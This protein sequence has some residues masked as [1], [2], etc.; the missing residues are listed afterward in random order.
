MDTLLQDI[1]YSARKLLRTPGFT[2]VAVATLALAIGATTAVFSLVNGILLQPLPYAAPHELVRVGSTRTGP[3]GGEQPVSMSRMDFLDYEA[4]STSF[5]GMAAINTTTLNL[6]G[7]GADPLRLD[8]A[9]VTVNFFDVLGVPLQ[10]GRGFAKGE[11]APGTGRVVVLSDAIWRS[12]FGADPG[13]VGREITLNGARH[14][15]VGIAPP[16]LTYPGR[17]EAWVPLAP[18][19][20]ELDPEN[21]GAHYLSG[22]GRLKPGVAPE[23]ARRELAT[24]AER[25]EAQ[26]PESNTNFG[27]TA[28]PLQEWIVGDVRPALYAMLGAVGFVL[29]I[30]CSNVANLL[31]VRASSRE[32][33]LAVRTALGAKRGRLVRQLVTESVMLSVAGA[34]LG[35]AIALWVVDAVVAL[36]PEGLPRLAEVRVDAR[37]LGATALLALL[38][39]VG[40]GLIPA[41]HAARS[42][43]GQ[44]LRESGRGTSHRK[45]TNR[46]RSL[47]VVTEFALAVVLLVGAGL[48]IRSFAALVRVD[49]GFRAENV[50]TATVSLPGGKYTY[51]R[52]QRAFADAVLERME[53]LPGAQS[54]ALGFGRPLQQNN[55]RTTFDVEGRPPNPPERRTPVEV[56]PTT[57]DFFRTLGIPLV[58]GRLYTRD[59]RNGAPPV[60][61]VNEEFVRR[62]FAGED[63]I[64]KRIVL[65]WGRDTAEVGES[66][67]VGGEI[68]GIVGDVKQFGL[69]E[70]TFPTAFL[71]FHQTPLSDVSIMVRSTAAPAAVQR[72]MRGQIKEIDPDLPVFDVMTM[73][74]ALAESVAQPRFYMMLL[75]GFAG[76]ALLLAALGIYGVISYTV[77]QRTRELGIRIALGASRQKVVGLVLGRGMVLTVVGVAAGLVAAYWLTRVLAS[78]LFGVEAL[79]APTYATVAVVLVAVSALA[80]WLPA[81]RAAHVDP[82]IAMRAE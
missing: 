59:D 23:A 46:T 78:L 62:Y 70:E 3:D 18:E 58:R 14:T 81:R 53:R 4:Q 79:D 57:P 74:D 61:V 6:S 36:G 19:P 80:S 27:G 49:P 71:A 29:L 35:S 73:T 45:A 82:V 33:E 9:R 5:E 20:W 8:A 12:R 39:G 51:D 1:R 28:I 54:V 55:F 10:R 24:I 17:R 41:L 50:V 77:S 64:G 42:E 32:T 75:A 31:L 13:L 40:F 2:V 21:R 48:L 76:V 65:G 37:V 26:Y 47:L 69:D 52:H 15:V 56:R 25:L 38:T 67:T 68:V 34:V 72:A 30:A 63:P 22:V 66:V 60:V 16:D 44:M 11:D 43:T 7:E